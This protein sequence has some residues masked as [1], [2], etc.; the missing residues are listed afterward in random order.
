MSR[1]IDEDDVRAAVTAI[2]DCNDEYVTSDYCPHCGARM[3]Q[4]A[5]D[6]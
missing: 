3:V 5:A 4:E 1:Y 6:E 2:Q